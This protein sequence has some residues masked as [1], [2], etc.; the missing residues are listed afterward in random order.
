MAD[1]VEAH[2]ALNDRIRA[3]LRTLDDEDDK[4][5]E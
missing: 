1:M 4:A 2:L 3:V 5:A